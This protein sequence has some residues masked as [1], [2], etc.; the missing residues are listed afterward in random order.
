M[1]LEMFINF[2]GDCREAVELYAK[3]FKSEV[4]NLMTYGDTPTDS[5]YEVPEADKD[6]IMY[7]GVPMGNMV[8]MCMDMPSGMPLV[9]GNNVMPTIS[10]PDKA[11]VRRVFEEFAKE[12]T[13]NTEPTPMFFSELFASVTDKFGV[14]WQILHYVPPAKEATDKEKSADKSAGKPRHKWTKEV[15]EIPFYVD[16]RES[17]ATVYWQTRKEMVIKKGAKM[18]KEAPMRKDGTPGMQDKAGQMLRDEHQDA[19]KDFVTTK[20][21]VLQSVN[22]VG[23]LLYFGGTNSWLELKDKDDKTLNEWTVVT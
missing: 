16:T 1:L 14:H 12:G 4:T 3:I 5:G 22:E 10:F 21:I 18:M 2:D 13:V 9:K 17:K 6:L 8:L 11:E 19:I 15:S 20:D 23:L 7:A